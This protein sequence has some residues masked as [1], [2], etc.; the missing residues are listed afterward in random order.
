MRQ[1]NALVM[2]KHNLLN[3]LSRRPFLVIAI[4]TKQTD[5]GLEDIDDQLLLLLRETY[6]K[7]Q[8]K[9]TLGSIDGHPQRSMRPS[10][11][12]AGRG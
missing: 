4:E 6:P 7:R 8:T 3:V 10:I 12:S 5:R 9:Q 2:L 11:A 1:H